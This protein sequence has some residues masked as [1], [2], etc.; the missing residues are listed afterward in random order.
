MTDSIRPRVFLRAA[1]LSGVRPRSPADGHT[2]PPERPV[3]VREWFVG[4]Y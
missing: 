2:F 3:E 1:G 4:Q